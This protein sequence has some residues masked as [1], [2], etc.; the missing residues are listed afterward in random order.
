MRSRVFAAL[1]LALL[2]GR[3]ASAQTVS[4]PG[5]WVLDVRGVTSPVP[6]EPVFY[7]TLHSSALVP[8]R[9]FGLDIGAHVYLFNL[10][11]S[12]VG[13]GLGAL[14]IRSK[15]APP[16]S[17]PTTPGEKPIPRQSI[18]LDLRTVTPQISFNF[19]SRDGWSYV[20]AGVGKT[21]I[22]ART[23]EV[24]IGRRE[25]SGLNS[26]NVGGGARWFLTSHLAFG[27]DLRFHRLSAGT[28]GAIELE[29]ARP[30]DPADPLEP[31]APAPPVP[32]A[33]TPGK[34]FVT[35]GAGFSIR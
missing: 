7:P 4:R 22:V 9:G 16:A 23:R 27:F 20:S 17:V 35:A 19:G 32:L 15:T 24:L 2:A 33:P 26:L 25:T 34:M 31:P 8:E 5:P 11:A 14:N 1:A 21:D 6:Q 10:G 13:I 18:E 12:R 30:A 29:A 28:A 3:H